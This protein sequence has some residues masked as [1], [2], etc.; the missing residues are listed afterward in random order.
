MDKEL[1]RKY[2]ELRNSISRLGSAIVAF[3][4]GV[5]STLVLKAAHDALG[6]K[7]VAVTADSP[8][9]PRRELEE[10]K[11]IARQIGARHLII[12]T[13]ET[14]NK[15]YLK[16]PGNRCYYCKLELYTKLKLIS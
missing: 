13:K 16:N 5:D 10:T 4:G 12:N 7:V 1:T 6:G 15:D 9:L 14:E 2:K 8:S 11:D 3:S